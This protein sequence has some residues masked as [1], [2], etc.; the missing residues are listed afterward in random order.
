MALPNLHTGKPQTGLKRIRL[1]QLLVVSRQFGISSGPS[2]V[3]YPD[4][5]NGS[6]WSLYWEFLCYLG[7]A[8]LGVTGVLLGKRIVVVG[9]TAAIWLLTVA[10]VF[11]TRTSSMVR[12]KEFQSCSD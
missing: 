10:P 8:V 1:E 2:D 6:L 9:L 5:W 11:E 12:T 3:P 7:V 4:V